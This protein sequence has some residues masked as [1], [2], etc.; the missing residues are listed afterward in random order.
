MHPALNTAWF[1]ENWK[2]DDQLQW[3]EVAEERLRLHY[4][5]SYRDQESNVQHQNVSPPPY[6]PR[7][8]DDFDDFLTPAT[9]YAQTTAVDEYDRYKS[10]HPIKDAFRK[11]IDWWRD[12]VD[13]Y[14][15]LS[16]MALDFFSVPAMSSECE[17]VFSLAKLILTTQRQHMNEMT[18]EAIL[19]LKLWW[20]DNAFS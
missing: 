12:H 2:E 4:D 17:R 3:L 5:R 15:T 8:P 19:C 14:P 1:V 10:L 6:P 20:R 18:L 9:F 13:E 7:E 11:P 16:R